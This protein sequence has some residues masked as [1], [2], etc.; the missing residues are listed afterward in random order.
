M[1]HDEHHEHLIKEVAEIFEPILSDSPQAIYIYL[2]DSHKICNQNFADLMGYGSIDEWVANEN[3]VG[4]FA[5][6]DQNNVIEAYEKASEE[7]LATSLSVVINTQGGSE[8][9]ADLIMTPFAYKGET[10]VVHF[11]TPQN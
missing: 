10:F 4:D 6:L 7:F 3:P 1:A 2:D 8:A 9:E 5:E 11:L